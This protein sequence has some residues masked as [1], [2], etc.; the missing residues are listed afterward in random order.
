MYE[1]RK[2]AHLAHLA[3]PIDS[4]FCLNWDSV[5]HLRQFFLVLCT[6]QAKVQ[7]TCISPF[8]SSTK[9]DTKHERTQ[10]P[11][12][13][14]SHKTGPDLGSGRAMRE[15]PVSVLEVETL[16][17]FNCI[18]KA[19]IKLSSSWPQVRTFYFKTEKYTTQPQHSTNSHLLNQPKIHMQLHYGFCRS[20]AWH[21]SVNTDISK[22]HTAIC[23][24]L[25]VPQATVQCD[26]DW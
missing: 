14:W 17:G 6:W 7:D 2:T 9:R 20:T 22:T 5:M 1:F 8:S 3:H 19:K 18:L 15:R 11:I 24:R 4:F 13:Y 21:L 26:E 16:H 10:N 25:A 23:C 12:R